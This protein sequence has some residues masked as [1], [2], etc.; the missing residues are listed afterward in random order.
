MNSFC[1]Y[2]YLTFKNE[3]LENKSQMYLVVDPVAGSPT[4]LEKRPDL[5]FCFVV[6]NRHPIRRLD[7]LL[8]S[9]LYKVPGPI[10]KQLL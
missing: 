9:E 8:V 2:T 10:L 7:T 6:D 1:W 3:N 4:E 5:H